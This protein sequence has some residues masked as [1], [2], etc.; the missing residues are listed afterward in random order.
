MMEPN[1]LA[2][3]RLGNKDRKIKNRMFIRCI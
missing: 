1:E 3:R 2:L